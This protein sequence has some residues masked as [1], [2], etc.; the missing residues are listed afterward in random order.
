MENWNFNNPEVKNEAAEATTEWDSLKT[1]ENQFFNPF[2]NV[3]EAPAA[4]AE[5]AEPA[6]TAENLPASMLDDNMPNPFTD[7][8]AA[9]AVEMPKSVLDVLDDVTPAELA[10]LRGEARGGSGELLERGERLR[11]RVFET[12]DG[13][14][15]ADRRRFHA[16]AEDLEALRIPGSRPASEQIYDYSDRQRKVNNALTNK[17]VELVDWLYPLD[18][19]NAATAS[20]EELRAK[21]FN[22]TEDFRHL[23]SDKSSE[24]VSSLSEIGRGLMSTH[25][26]MLMEQSRMFLTGSRENFVNVAAD[27]SPQ[28][29]QRMLNY[30]ENPNDTTRR[31]W[32]QA[33]YAEDTA[34]NNSFSG[35][36]NIL[37]STQGR[38]AENLAESTTALR[39]SLSMGAEDK[40][41]A[42]LEYVDFRM[43][44]SG[45]KTAVEDEAKSP[46]KEEQEPAKTSQAT[47]L[48]DLLR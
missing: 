9:P 11:A 25:N 1:V 15:M 32:R 45:R 46:F 2:T 27:Y 14:E 43:E 42:M 37:Y 28:T 31:M 41:K 3:V 10:K 23:V 18:G 21:R 8:P 12:Y 48:A 5:K 38:L 34:R 6:V 19:E 26:P 33:L 44:N 47:L 22:L 29:A 35:V 36:M 40:F 30:L 17:M 7:A 4:P 24:E 39:R 13:V 16:A 20:E